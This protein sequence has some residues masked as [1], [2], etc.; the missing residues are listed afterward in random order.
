[1]AKKVFSWRGSLPLYIFTNAEAYPFFRTLILESK[2]VEMEITLSQTKKN[3]CILLLS[4]GK[5]NGFYRLFAFVGWQCEWIQSY[6]YYFGWQREW[7]YSCLYYI[8]NGF[9]YVLAFEILT[10]SVIAIFLVPSQTDPFMLQFRPTESKKWPTYLRSHRQSANRVKFWDS[11][12]CFFDRDRTK[13]GRKTRPY[14]FFF[15]FFFFFF[16]CRGFE[17]LVKQLNSAQFCLQ[18]T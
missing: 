7:I 15:F 18:I 4:A 8:V 16:S 13:S 2:I 9:N 17:Q 10:F 3:H 12:R 11:V 5:V 6:L 1:M 14:S